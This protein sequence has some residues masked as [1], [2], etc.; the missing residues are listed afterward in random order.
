MKFKR[1]ARDR[2]QKQIEEGDILT[3]GDTLALVRKIIRFGREEFPELKVTTV[4]TDFLGRNI[5]LGHT[6]YTVNEYKRT[7]LLRPELLR[8]D[9]PKYK[10]VKELR[11]TV[12]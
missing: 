1:Q 8:D 7:R 10:K 4:N 3:S 12:I 6:T 9:V 2:T 11:E 5:K